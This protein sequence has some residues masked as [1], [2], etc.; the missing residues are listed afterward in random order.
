MKDPEIQQIL[1]D[2]M[3]KITL[4]NMQNDP[5]TAADVMK[6]PGMSAKINKLIMAGIVKMA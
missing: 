4:Q 1:M 3:V 2:P 5:K 6:D